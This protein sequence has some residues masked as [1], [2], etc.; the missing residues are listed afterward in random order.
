MADEVAWMLVESGWKVVAADGTELGSVQEVLGD[1][2]ADIFN[3]IAVSPG[4]LRRAR[5]LPAE[6]VTRIVEG[7]LEVDVDSAAFD[8]LAEAGDAPPGAGPTDAP[9]TKQR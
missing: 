7:R 3:G 8:R 6:R 2:S 9:G 4:L 1:E 5:Y